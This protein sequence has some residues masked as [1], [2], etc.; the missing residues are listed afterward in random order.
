MSV[1]VTAIEIVQGHHLENPER[2]IYFI[3]LIEPEGVCFGFGEAATPEGAMRE[4]E[5][6]AADFGLPPERII[7]LGIA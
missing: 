4:A 7:P 3:N 1:N 6:L 5:E 2:P